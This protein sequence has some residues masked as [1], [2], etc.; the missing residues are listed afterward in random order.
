M[1]L[2]QTVSLR[3]TI[4]ETNSFSI[5]DNNNQHSVN[6]LLTFDTPAWRALIGKG[7]SKFSRFD[8]FSW[9]LQ[10]M[11]AHD[12]DS[13]P[14]PISVTYLNLAE[15][16]KWS[17]P[18]VQKFIEELEASKALTKRKAGNTFVLTAVIQ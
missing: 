4:S 1:I 3:T 12:G 7:N 15:V 8:A 18:T 11:Y 5:M 17:R 2:T 10:K 16:W 13:I 6:Y 9:L 14:H